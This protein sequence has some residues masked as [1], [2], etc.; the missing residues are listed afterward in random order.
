MAVGADTLDDAPAPAQVTGVRV[1]RPW[2]GSAGSA[3]R[4]MAEDEP[5]TETDGEY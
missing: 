2:S 1:A 4:G 3:R 5:E